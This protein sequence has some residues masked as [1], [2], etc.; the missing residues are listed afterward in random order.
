M[1]IYDLYKYMPD[2]ILT[3]VDKASM[4]NSL[5]VRCPLLG[6]RLTNS[7]FL[8]NKSKINGSFGKYKLKTIRKIFRFKFN[9]LKKRFRHSYW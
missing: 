1:Q 9:I 5:E 7:I 4:A 8:Q 3:K 2:D 6:H